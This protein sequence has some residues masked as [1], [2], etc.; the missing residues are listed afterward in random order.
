MRPADRQLPAWRLWT[1]VTLATAAALFYLPALTQTGGLWPAPL[2]DVYIYFGHARATALGSVLAWF[3]GYGY[4]SGAT[5]IIYPWLLAPAWALGLRGTSLGVAAALLAW[6]CLFD[7]CCSL[8]RLMRDHVASWLAAP[9]LT[10]V[11]LLSWSWWSGMETALFGAL[12]GRCLRAADDSWRAP[13]QRRRK[14]QWHVGGWLALLVLTRPESVVLASLLGVA[15][16]H[17]A[18]SLGTLGSIGRTLGTPMAALAAQAAANRAW[19]GEWSQA[20]AIRKLVWS[21]P[22][23]DVATAAVVVAQNVAVLLSQAFVRALG[24]LPKLLLPLMLIVA[25]IVSPRHRRLGLA[26]TL[27]AAGGLLLISLNTTARFQNLRYAA[28]LLAMLLCAAA[29]GLHALARKHRALTALGFL[30][31]WAPMGELERQTDHFAQ[32]SSNILQ[33]QGEVA[34]RLRAM[35]PRP[36]RVLVNDAGVIPYLSELPPLDGL[37][38]GGFRGMP[39]A[40]ASVQGLGA[41]VELI[42][43]LPPHDRPDVMAVYPDWWSGVVDVFGRRIDA[44]RIEHNVIC[45]ADE[46]VIYAADWSTL[47]LPSAAADIDVA[48][49]MDERAHGVSGRGRIVST[50]LLDGNERRWDAGRVVVDTLSFD[51]PTRTKR[52][53]LRIDDTSEGTVRL[54]GQERSLQRSATGR[55]RHLEVAIDDAGASQLTVE[56]LKGAVGIYGVWLSDG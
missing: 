19:T 51:V 44:V 50:T 23:A 2:D 17:G 7:L 33:Q 52:V 41:V 45:A 43:R 24:G 13:P 1:A 15:V 49:L 5:S 48:D 55:W 21:S 35:R 16:V 27:G 31:V 25:A 22:D 39:F 42:E 18:R 20:G 14:V 37:G 46:K 32:A 6:L 29:L 9:L 54:G 28:P 36:Q 12:L 8:R 4:S 38:L 47:S 3:P 30:A 56:I 26:L 53:R 10:A 11:P 34:R 40:R